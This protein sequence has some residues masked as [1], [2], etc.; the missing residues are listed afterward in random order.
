MFRREVPVEGVEGLGALAAVPAWD[1]SVS[2]I[3]RLRLLARLDPRVGERVKDADPAGF[4]PWD[5]ASIVEEVQSAIDILLHEG[6]AGDQAPGWTEDA[7]RRVQAAE[8][9]MT[10]RRIR[11]WPDIVRDLDGRAI[12]VVPL[13]YWDPITKQRVYNPLFPLWVAI[14]MLVRDPNPILALASIE[15][16]PS[17]G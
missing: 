3:D 14:E 16:E 10:R 12:F 15:P 4:F 6:E 9:W 8:A 5:R 7:N 17:G 2:S 1:W 11:C 13:A